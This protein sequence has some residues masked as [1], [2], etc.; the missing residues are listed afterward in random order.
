MIAEGLLKE[1]DTKGQTHLL[2]VV[3]KAC[4]RWMR[5]ATAGLRFRVALHFTDDWPT[6][7]PSLT[8]FSNGDHEGLQESNPAGFVITLS[9]EVSDYC[10]IGP[11]CAQLETIHPRLGGA[12]IA[13]MEELADMTIGAF[14]PWNAYGA[15]QHLHWMGEVDH[16]LRLEEI[17]EC[18]ISHENMDYLTLFE[19]DEG[20][21]DICVAVEWKYGP[22]TPHHIA[23]VTWD[24]PGDVTSV[25]IDVLDISELILLK[26]DFHERCPEWACEHHSNRMTPETLRKLARKIR[27]PA[28]RECVKVA[29]ELEDAIRTHPILSDR[30]HVPTLWESPHP[31]VFG[32]TDADHCMVARMY[33]DI[34]NEAMQAGEYTEVRNCWF[35]PLNDERA[36]R[37]AIRQVKR[38][39]EHLYLLE[40]A[41]LVVS[42][43]I[44]R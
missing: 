2:P 15:C 24:I 13:A 40:K 8:E 44:Y 21:G 37:K 31:L 18:E 1:S 39:F 26:E 9:S 4:E 19:I 29:A 17:I 14:G 43:K 22:N 36:I 23:S 16:K 41:L 11:R 5:Q 20:H 12:V 30:G 33:D 28:L 3:T 25:W 32:L 10:L 35:F 42:T 27:V 34:V 7:F 6:H 38:T